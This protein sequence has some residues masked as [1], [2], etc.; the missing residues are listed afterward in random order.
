MVFLSS[1]CDSRISSYNF[2]SGLLIN[3]IA[4]IGLAASNYLQQICSSPSL[5]EI[6]KH[7]KAGRDVIFGSNSPLAVYRLKNTVLTVLWTSLILT[8]LPLHLLVNG[9][10]GYA[11]YIVAA[12]SSAIEI[13][14]R[15]NATIPEYAR[16]WTSIS[17]D[18]CA[19]FL[20]R[21]IA[22]VTDFN[23]ITILVYENASTPFA[24]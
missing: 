6:E 24:F 7:L 23:N 12:D 22:Y 4:S 10:V 17:S 16:N 11:I 5:S 21:S 9:V 19:Q 1:T 18:N 14:V 2:L 15:G 8:S 3:V 20:V 13:P